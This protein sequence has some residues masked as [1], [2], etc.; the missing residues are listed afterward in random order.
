MADKEAGRKAMLELNRCFSF[1]SSDEKIG[2]K[3]YEEEHYNP[4][5]LYVSHI[6][7]DVSEEELRIV[8]EP[9]GMIESATILKRPDGTNKGCG[10]VKFFTNESAV[11]AIKSLHH[12]YQME[13]SEFNLIVKFASRNDITFP[14]ASGAT[15]TKRKQPPKPNPQQPVYAYESVAAPPAESNAN[16]GDYLSYYKAFFAL[17]QAQQRE[18][19]L[20]QAT[21]SSIRPAKRTRTAFLESSNPLC[22]LYVGNIPVQY[23]ESDLEGMFSPFGAVKCAYLMAE[24]GSDL[25]KGCGFV[26]FDDEEAASV[27]I[28]QLDGMIIG[29]KRL[30]VSL[31]KRSNA[32][33]I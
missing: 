2:V 1:P 13:G 25:N 14:N 24:K 33:V 15:R 23:T 17:Q 32:S 31:K 30:R 12:N 18:N 29:G 27:A 6:P 20:S 5:K 10:F 26:S 3:Y 16:F 11:Q 8:F 7:Q 22:N 21:S 9:F 4:R 19:E 28:K